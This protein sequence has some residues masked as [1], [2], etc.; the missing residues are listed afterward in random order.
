MEEDVIYCRED[1]LYIPCKVYSKEKASVTLT[2]TQTDDKVRVTD[3]SKVM[4]YCHQATAM[5]SFVTS[6]FVSKSNCGI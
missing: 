6:T 1:G 2:F 3:L 4:L 5:N